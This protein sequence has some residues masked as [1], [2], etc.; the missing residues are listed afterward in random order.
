MKLNIKKL[1]RTIQKSIIKEAF[2][3]RQLRMRD[4]HIKE[5]VK[6]NYNIKDI[7]DSLSAYHGTGEFFDAAHQ[8]SFRI[9]KEIQI[10]GE[11]PYTDPHQLIKMIGKILLIE[12]FSLHRQ[13]LDRQEY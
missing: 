2:S 13:Y 5:Y 10:S 1:R 12:L 11:F 6:N 8:E 9:A 7:F 3:R 4:K